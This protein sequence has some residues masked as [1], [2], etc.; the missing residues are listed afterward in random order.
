MRTAVVAAPRYIA[1]AGEPKSPSDLE[2]HELVLHGK[3]L[4]SEELVLS[5]PIARSNGASSRLSSEF[6][7]PVRSGHFEDW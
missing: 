3:P 6:D 2:R 1:R 5:G 7:E 4:Q